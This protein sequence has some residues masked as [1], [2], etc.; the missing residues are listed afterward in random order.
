[1]TQ[2]QLNDNLNERKKTSSLEVP[3]HK[4]D[5]FDEALD[6]EIARTTE[7]KADAEYNRKKYAQAKD[8]IR[9]L[10][11]ERR[12]LLEQLEGKN[13]QITKLRRADRAGRNNEVAESRQEMAMLN[14]VADRMRP[15]R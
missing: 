7:A 12:E 15:K 1:M 4:I 6:K 13:T 14:F 8:K 5:D 9:E 10:E 2:E 3:S 11:E